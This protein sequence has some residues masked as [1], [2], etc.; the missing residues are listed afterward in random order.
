[1]ERVFLYLVSTESVL[2]LLLRL[3]ILIATFESNT[4]NLFAPPTLSCFGIKAS[5]VP[6]INAPLANS[7]VSYLS[8]ASENDS[9]ASDPASKPRTQVL[10]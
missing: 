5:P 8:T 9:T 3:I 4:S 7:Y 10:S 1:M 6:L 2:L